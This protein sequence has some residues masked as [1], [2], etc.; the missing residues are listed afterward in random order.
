MGFLARAMW[1]C[2]GEMQL[3]DFTYA[4]RLTAQ[5]AKAVEVAPLSVPVGGKDRLLVTIQNPLNEEVVLEGS[6]SSPHTFSV[7][8]NVVLPSGGAVAVPIEYAPCAIGAR[9]PP[10]KHPLPQ[11]TLTAPQARTRRLVHA[12]PSAICLS[13]KKP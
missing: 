11:R 4:L 2:V 3:G 9:S 13:T 1:S 7:P 8:F 5:D 6:S 12:C 10:T